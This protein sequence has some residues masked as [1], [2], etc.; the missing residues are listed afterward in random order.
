MSDKE[1]EMVPGGRKATAQEWL[2]WVPFALKEIERLRRA[3]DDNAVDV[4]TEDFSFP[5]P[6]VAGK[7]T[8]IRIGANNYLF[9]RTPHDTLI[10][11]GFDVAVDT[12]DDDD[13]KP[14]DPSEYR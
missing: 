5:G 9:E 14:F 1:I 11:V 8:T 3:L 10:Y 13:P 7:Y 12:D 4:T 2:D 6:E